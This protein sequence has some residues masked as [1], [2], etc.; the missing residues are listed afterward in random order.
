MSRQ[1]FIYPDMFTSEDVMSLSRDARYLFVGMFATADDHGR[2]KASPRH[3]AAALFPGDGLALDELERC[4]NEVMSAGMIR[5]YVVEGTEYYDIPKWEKWQKP[6][7][8]AKSK[9]PEY[10]ANGSKPP[11]GPRGTPG[12]SPEGPRTREE[13]RGEEGRG[14]EKRKSDPPNPPEGGGGT[15]RRSAPTN[16]KP[17]PE[18]VRL[19]ARFEAISGH[20]AN[21]AS[22]RSAQRLIARGKAEALARAIENYAAYVEAEDKPIE[23]RIAPHNWF[24]R[25]SRWQEHTERK[26]QAPPIT[27]RPEPFV[28]R[29]LTEAE[30]QARR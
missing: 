19:V 4:R 15:V 10:Q 5:V 28:N 6:R 25:A 26:A 2:G 14:E 12:G 17:G 13:K 24:G 29:P 20:K 30:K 18:A 7:Y 27:Q 3:L 23:Y 9:V 21:D 1:R 16:R 8:K 22:K 11:E